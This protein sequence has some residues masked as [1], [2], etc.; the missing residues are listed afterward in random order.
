MQNYSPDVNTAVQESLY[1]N[2]WEQT[3]CSFNAYHQA[4]LKPNLVNLYCW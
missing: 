1:L 2:H 4:E 3:L